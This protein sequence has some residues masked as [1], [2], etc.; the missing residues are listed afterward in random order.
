MGKKDKHNQR[1]A[2]DNQQSAS[3]K[4]Q[5]ENNSKNTKNENYSERTLELFN[6]ISTYYCDLFCNSMYFETEEI[7]KKNSKTIPKKDIYQQLIT[8][9]LDDFKKIKGQDNAF[10]KLMKSLQ[11]KMEATVSEK[12]GRSFHLTPV[13]FMNL[14]AA[15]I[16]PP[17]FIKALEKE[18]EPIKS[19]MIIVFNCLNNVIQ[20]FCVVISKNYLN[21][22][23]LDHNKR[24]EYLNDFL[25]MKE[26]FTNYLL[27]ERERIYLEFLNPNAQKK[28][29]S[30]NDL[31]EKLIKKT[32]SL[33]TENIN[34][35]EQI[36]IRDQYIIAL[37]NELEH[38]KKDRERLRYDMLKILQ[39]YGIDVEALKKFKDSSAA[40]SSIVGI[41]APNYS[42][43]LQNI[44]DDN[45]EDSDENKEDETHE[46]SDDSDDEDEDSDEAA[47]ESNEG[48]FA[49]ESDEDDDESS[50]ANSDEAHEGSDNLSQEG[51]DE[52][53]QEANDEHTKKSS[54]KIS[55]DEKRKKKHTE[56][57]ASKFL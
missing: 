47:H 11:M 10:Q 28:G 35:K 32:L 23:L 43:M 14:L 20:K 26:D 34:L 22:I 50:G 31:E 19:K 3:G 2:S 44:D 49:H 8:S 25:Q 53:S 21:I 48:S 30:D 56:E 39:S 27:S 54:K 51:S 1:S 36:H 5:K 18:K 57:F 6:I 9:F 33:T 24:S 40:H 4:N 52:V 17:A 38:Q 45:Q 13:E 15:E 37:K 42:E 12:T 46:G 7:Y 55:K 41:K 16:L 29:V